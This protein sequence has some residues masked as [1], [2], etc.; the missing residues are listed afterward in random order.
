M[1]ASIT[2]LGERGRSS[3]WPVTVAFFVAGSTIAAAVLG[4]AAGLLGALVWP[5]RS[6]GLHP[7]LGVLATAIAVSILMDLG[8]GGA[9][10][11]SVRRQVNEAWLD[12]YRGWVYGLGFGVQL[13]LGVTT[14]V[15]TSAVYVTLVA[16]W[17]TADPAL[18]A[19]VVGSFGFV[20]GISLLAAAG[21]RS[22][23]QLVALHSR[24]A[25][26]RRRIRAI[27]LGAQAGLLAVALA[28]SVL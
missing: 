12:E 26:W 4:A 11:P 17:L 6:G 23:A 21:V 8:L 24:L 19:L 1:L 15:T 3:R 2:P 5:A 20:R 27:G 10:V 13:G 25:A 14:I 28:A 16:A 18:G 7:R 22:T 9:R